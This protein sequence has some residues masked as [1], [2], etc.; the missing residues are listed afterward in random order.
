[1]LNSS[2]YVADPAILRPGEVV[3]ADFDLSDPEVKT[4]Y[5]QVPGAITHLPDGSTLQFL[6]GQYSTKNPDILRHLEAIADKV[7]T[8]VFTK[9]N[10]HIA[11]EIKRSA[12]EASLPVA[13][14]RNVT[15]E[16][17]SGAQSGLVPARG[18]DDGLTKQVSKEVQGQ[19]QAE[20]Q[21]SD[22]P[23]LANKEL[24]KDLLNR[25]KP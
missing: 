1:M 22:S 21:H 4:F 9:S 25:N 6:G 11:A 18:T 13:E 15:A 2:N 7:G 16:K 5:H 3:T 23:S 20:R 24:N 12:L 8:M 19:S 14:Q 17:L 10:K